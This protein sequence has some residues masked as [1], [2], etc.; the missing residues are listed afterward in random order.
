MF[1]YIC[2]KS[3]EGMIR[4]EDSTFMNEEDKRKTARV[5]MSSKFKNTNV[6]TF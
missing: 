3:S 6:F 4:F 5:Q 1:P 2:S